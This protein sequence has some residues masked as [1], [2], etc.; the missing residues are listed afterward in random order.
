MEGKVPW[1]YMSVIPCFAMEEILY[2]F[3]LGFILSSLLLLLGFMTPL[4]CFP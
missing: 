4:I 2:F 3:A 1:S